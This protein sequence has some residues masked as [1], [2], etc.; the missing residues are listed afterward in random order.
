MVCTIWVILIVPSPRKLLNGQGVRI[1]SGFVVM[2]GSW[3]IGS[4]RGRRIKLC[5]ELRKSKVDVY[6]LQKIRWKGR[7]AWFMG[8]IERRYKF[9]H[10]GTD[11][12]TGGVKMLVKKEVC[13]EV[14]EVRRRN[15]RIMAMVMTFEKEMLKVICVYGPRNGKPITEKQQFY[16]KTKYVCTFRIGMIS[17]SSVDGD[18]T[19]LKF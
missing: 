15:D 7:G 16:K 6:Y 14:V 9:L 1:I 8:V 12:G 17:A 10:A 13:D 3:N 11:F 19:G 4:I 18:A 5:E 2:V